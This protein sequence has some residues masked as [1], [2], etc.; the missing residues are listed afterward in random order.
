MEILEPV[1]KVRVEYVHE[2]DVWW[3]RANTNLRFSAADGDLDALKR[4]VHDALEEILGN[5]VIYIEVVHD[6][7][8]RSISNSA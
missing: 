8:I 4:Q 2:G 1:N 3:A 5:Q 6:P 7:Q